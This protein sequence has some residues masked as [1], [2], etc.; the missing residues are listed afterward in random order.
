MIFFILNKILGE[1]YKKNYHHIIFISF[2]IQYIQL[3]A[4]RVQSGYSGGFG[5][6]LELISTKA[7][8]V[9]NNIL[10]KCK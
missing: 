5:K 2:S 8:F 4:A 7:T 1:I 6:I 9:E 3:Y 10:V